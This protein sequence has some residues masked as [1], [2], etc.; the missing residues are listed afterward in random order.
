MEQREAE[1]EKRLA[2]AMSEQQQLTAVLEEKAAEY[3][4]ARREQ[5]ED[6][7]SFKES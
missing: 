6:D 4:L 3:A 1:Y 7:E 5:I 2:A